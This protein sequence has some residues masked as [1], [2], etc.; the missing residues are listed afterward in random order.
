MPGLAEKLLNA[1]LEEIKHR[2]EMEKLELDA[3]VELMRCQ[4]KEVFRGQI[5]AFLITL[6]FA[7]AGVYV[8]C[9]GHSVA[10][11]V[12]GG[13]GLGSIVSP[14]TLPRPPAM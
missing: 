2:R 10:G 13:V 8:I 6:G 3:E 5:F 12:F 11:T 4:T 1:A 14:F 9:S 7:G